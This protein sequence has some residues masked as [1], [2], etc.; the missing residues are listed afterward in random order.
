MFTFEDCL[1]G[2]RDKASAA[3]EAIA[4]VFPAVT[5]KGVTLTVP[6]PAHPISASMEAEIR[7]QYSELENLI[8]RC[9]PG[10]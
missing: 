5:T 8:E 6:M 10:K 9:V 3:A 2:G 4:K 7:K 1:N